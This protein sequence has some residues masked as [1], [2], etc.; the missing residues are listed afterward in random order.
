MD[1]SCNNS[2]N[3]HIYGING[4]YLLI[5][6]LIVLHA[7]CIMIMVNLADKIITCYNSLN[8]FIKR[9]EHLQNRVNNFSTLVNN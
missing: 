3:Y 6:L 2:L 4:V 5:G 1:N 7:L 8:A 9:V